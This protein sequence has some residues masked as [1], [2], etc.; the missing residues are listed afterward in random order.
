MFKIHG[1]SDAARICIE[2]LVATMRH[3]DSR[4]Y[5]ARDFATAI[6]KS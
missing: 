2:R 5:C 4:S 3:G 6:V 1:L